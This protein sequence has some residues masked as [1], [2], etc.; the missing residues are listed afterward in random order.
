MCPSGVKRTWVGGTLKLG[1]GISQLLPYA[2]GAGRVRGGRHLCFWN[3]KTSY[4]TFFWL[5]LISLSF[6]V[7]LH[8]CLLPLTHL[9][10]Y[11]SYPSPAPPSLCSIFSIL[12]NYF[13]LP[14]LLLF[15]PLPPPLKSTLYC[16]LSSSILISSTQMHPPP[17]FPFC[18]LSLLPRLRQWR[19]FS[20]SAQLL[21]I[22]DLICRN[23]QAS[24]TPGPFV[25]SVLLLQ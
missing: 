5:S 18:C 12:L 10:V 22:N 11:L 6:K 13:M 8:P 21:Q 20:I 16:Y 24:S 4:F 9:S 25:S 23:K 7:Q 15:F 2:L 3:V 17:I 19:T 1:K 14:P